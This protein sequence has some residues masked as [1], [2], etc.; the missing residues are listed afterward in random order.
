M[1]CR[2]ALSM[3]MLCALLLLAMPTWS[4]QADDYYFIPDSDT[5]KLTAKELRAYSLS[6][7]GYIRNEIL[8]RYGFPF[9]TKKYRDHFNNQDWYYPDQSFEYSWLS[10]L[11]MDN[12]ELIKKVEQ[13]KQEGEGGGSSGAGSDTDSDSGADYFIEDSGTRLLT[14]SELRAYSL[15]DLGFIRN[16]IL[17]RHGYPF[18]TD[19]YRDYFDSMWWYTRD[20]DFDMDSLSSTEMKNVQLVQQIEQEKK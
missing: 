2:R 9:K 6:D 11:E 15:S 10:N 3:I 20:E 1:C 8:A 13:E 12:V 4:A 18:K 19:K 17:A 5:R 16:E 7:L 14:K